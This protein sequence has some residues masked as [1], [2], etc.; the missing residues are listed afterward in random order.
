M[1]LSNAYRWNV[2]VVTYGF[3]ESFIRYFG[4]NGVAAVEGAIQELNELPTASGVQGSNSLLGSYPSPFQ[5]YDLKSATLP[6]LLEQLGLGPP[7]GNMYVIRQWTNEALNP[8]FRN[9]VNGAAGI[10][11]VERNYDPDNLQP[12]TSV[13]GYAYGFQIAEWLGTGTNSVILFME[14]YGK[15]LIDNYQFGRPAVADNWLMAGQYYE[16]LT[17]DDVGGLR[18]LFS[19]NHVAYETLLPDVSSAGSGPSALVDGALRPGVEKITF[20]RQPSD[21]VT[22]KFLSMTNRFTDNFFTNG[23]VAQQQVQ[24]VTQ[25]PDFLFSAG[26]TTVG[27]PA[28]YTISRTG[29]SQWVNNAALNGNPGGEGPGVITPPVKITF[30]KL[31]IMILPD[32]SNLTLPWQSF[33]GSTN[34]PIQYPVTSG[35]TNDVVMHLIWGATFP[36]LSKNVLTWRFSANTGALFDFQKSSNLMTWNSLATITNDGTISMYLSSPPTSSA[37]FFRLVPKSR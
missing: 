18:Y 13:S 1:C 34:A 27:I 21:S 2:P 9:D 3:D 11:V 22:G 25:S 4:S 35:P 10:D 20:V 19:S 8:S 24:R 7:T 36:D 6:L 17:G 32:G 5:G 33:D 15:D 23:I 28:E 14:P 16:G 37:G 29:T 26:D 30:Q 12:S 31:G